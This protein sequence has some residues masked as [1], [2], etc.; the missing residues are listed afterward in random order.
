MRTWSN[1]LFSAVPIL[2]PVFFYIDIKLVAID[3][4]RTLVDLH[5]DRGDIP[6]IAALSRNLRP[7][8]ARFIPLALEHNILIAIVTFSRH[9]E[10]IYSLLQYTYGKI[11]AD[12][13]IIRGND[14][15]WEYVGR[16]PFTPMML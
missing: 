8:F 5:T 3:F 12:R 6:D 1:D 15:S 13:I 4:D 10:M 9:V 11:I 14:N 2:I 7:F 16:R